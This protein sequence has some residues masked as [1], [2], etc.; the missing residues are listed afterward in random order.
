MTFTS[1]AQ[2][3]NFD[4]VRRPDYLPTLEE[5]QRREEESMR[6]YGEAERANDQVR[7]QNAKQSGEGL[8]ALGKFSKTL[9]K[10]LYA[11][12]EKQN[13]RDLNEG[14]AAAYEEGMYGAG[15]PERMALD[16]GEAQL[17]ADDAELGFAS[18]IVMNG[19]GENYQ[20][21]RSVRNMSGWK[22]YGYASGKAQIAGQQYGS[23]ME[24]ALSTDNETQI[25]IGDQTFT[26]AQ[27]YTPQQTQAAMAVLRR[28]YMQ[29][30]GV[31][32][33]AKPLLAKY[34]FETMMK[35]DASMVGA[36]RKNYA[37]AES[38]VEAGE[39]DNALFATKDL[40]TY[41][42]SLAGT[43]DGQGKARGFA[44]AWPEAMTRIEN[45]VKAGLL[46]ETD[47]VSYTHLT[48]PTTD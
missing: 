23:W 31:S 29:Q 32:G 13:E 30:A 25:T 17:K 35:S 21:S 2:G 43:V 34:M 1:Y 12:A 33:L 4:P 18:S 47:P 39:A 26:P 8:I 6:A 20:A 19:Q 41:L 14:I 27:A 22:Q 24:N 38:R 42:N 15:S 16:M 28:Q 36:A 44:G 9:S 11:E 40:G 37:I 45:A 46:N 5:N 7:I 10:V 48:L 3:G